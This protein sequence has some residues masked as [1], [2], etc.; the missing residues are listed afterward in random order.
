MYSRQ[1]L[2]TFVIGAALQLVGRLQRQQ[3]AVRG[4]HQ[5]SNPTK[6]RVVACRA[7]MHSRHHAVYKHPLLQ[8]HHS[9]LPSHLQLVGAGLHQ[10]CQHLQSP[11][12][13]IEVIT[14]LWLRP[15]QP[16]QQQHIVWCSTDEVSVDQG[17]GWGCLQQQG[18]KGAMVRQ[19]IVIRT[20]AQQGQEGK[21]LKNT[22]QKESQEYDLHHP[23]SSVLPAMH[24]HG[25]GA[26]PA[27]A[28]GSGWAFCP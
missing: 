4:P 20:A 3:A 6:T 7:H 27:A 2:N 12:A 28:L 8:H 9:M 24:T 23:G 16:Q 11:I 25:K 21:S 14:P 22:A 17:R 15:Q 13:H 10:A 18:H 26:A 19:Q 1:G 5:W